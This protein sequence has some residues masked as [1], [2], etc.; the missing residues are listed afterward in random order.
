MLAML[1]LMYPDIQMT[2][3]PSSV[4]CCLVSNFSST[5]TPKSF[6]TELNP[7]ISQSVLIFGIALTQVQD[8]ALGLIELHEA[9]KGLLLKPVQVPLEYKFIFYNDVYYK[10]TPLITEV[11]LYYEFW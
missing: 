9:C 7:F 6:S 8:C 2:F 1:L 11:I 5:S 10:V 4:H 3:W